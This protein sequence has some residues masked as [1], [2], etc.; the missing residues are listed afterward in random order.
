MSTRTTRALRPCLERAEDRCLATL[1]PMVSHLGI[2]ALAGHVHRAALGNPHVPTILAEGQGRRHH[3]PQPHRSGTTIVVFGGPGGQGALPSNYQDWGV[4]SIWNST[5]SRVTFSASASTYQQGRYYN[6]TLRPGQHQSY[7]AV[8]NNLGGAP[9]F[10]VSFDPI[11]RSNPVLISD[12]NTVFERMNW[13]PKV[14]TEGRPYA[15][16]VDVSGLHLTPI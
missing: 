2:H 16:A 10:R 15:I 5:N 8:F 3:A 13:F 1:P 7:Y 4:I 14:G 12:I 9:E 11:H 6:F